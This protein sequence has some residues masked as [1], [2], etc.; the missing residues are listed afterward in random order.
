[1]Y[2]S[3]VGRPMCWS[4]LVLWTAQTAIDDAAHEAGVTWEP[5]HG[6]R[7]RHWFVLVR[8]VAG[9]ARLDL[10]RAE[11]LRPFVVAALEQ[12]DTEW[13]WHFQRSRNRDHAKVAKS[14]QEASENLF[15]ALGWTDDPESEFES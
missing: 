3:E 10:V 7:F 5:P 9:G 14:L 12:L 1:M 8:A 15:A 11:H 2:W 4:E 13:W 6:E